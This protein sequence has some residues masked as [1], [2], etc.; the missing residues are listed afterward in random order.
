MGSHGSGKQGGRQRGGEGSSRS[1]AGF[2]KRRRRTGGDEEDEEREG[3][4]AN[5]RY[6]GSRA[7]SPLVV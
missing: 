5:T 6:A 4:L 1:L 7:A 3:C 2:P